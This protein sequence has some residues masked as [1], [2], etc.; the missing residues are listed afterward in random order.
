MLEELTYTWI[1]F[2]LEAGSVPKQKC[3]KGPSKH[4]CLTSYPK[5]TSSF[6][7]ANRWLSALACISLVKSSSLLHEANESIICSL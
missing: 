5:S 3:W 6:N 7:T 2:I 4:S 1:S